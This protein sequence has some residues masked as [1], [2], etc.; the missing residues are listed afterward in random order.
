MQRRT[1]STPHAP[2][3]IG[4]YSQAVAITGAA[5]W[6][7]CSGQIA[8]D[9]ATGQMQNGSVEIEARTCMENLKAV[10]GASGAGLR[11]VVRCT[12]YLTD[13]A[14]FDTVN[15]IYGTYFPEDPPAR[16]AIAVAGLP[17]GA[18]VE[19]EAIAALAFRP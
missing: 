10:L 8:L 9:P 4:A 15:R 7:Y 3:A 5:I 17:K 18:R 1:T 12:I 11:D 6:V 19:V 14:D 13:M 16:A 2:A